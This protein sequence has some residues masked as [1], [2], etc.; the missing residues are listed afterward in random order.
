[1]NSQTGLDINDTLE[2][3]LAADITSLGGV[4]KVAKPMLWPTKDEITAQGRLRA[5][6]A[7]NHAQ[8][9]SMEEMQLII[10]RAARVGSFNTITYL[11][12]KA[13]GQFTRVEPRTRVE[14]LM[15][16]VDALNSTFTQTVADLQTAIAD[17][18][19]SDDAQDR[20]R[21]IR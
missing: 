15:E 10:E 9:L 12:G 1:V 17:L 20:V 8:E 19:D 14:L 21:S 3:A 11:C 4:K 5:A 13:R 18:K 7:P 6:L 16:R 2:A